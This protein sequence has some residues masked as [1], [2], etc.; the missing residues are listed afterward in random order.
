MVLL[1]GVKVEIALAVATR[2]ETADRECAD[3]L[4]MV[5][6]VMVELRSDTSLT[7]HLVKSAA[8]H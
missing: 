1:V 7:V 6:I 3:L 5:L 8:I 2:I 4:A